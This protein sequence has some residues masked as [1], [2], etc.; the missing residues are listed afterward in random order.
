[1]D[2]ARKGHTAC[3]EALVAAKAAPD[4]KSVRYVL[5]FACPVPLI[6]CLSA[7]YDII[8]I[9]NPSSIVSALGYR[10]D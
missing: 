4:I 3:V 9:C 7:R 8:V 2:A 1:M 5:L 6:L 10:D